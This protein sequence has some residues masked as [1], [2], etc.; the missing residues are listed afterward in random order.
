MVKPVVKE[1]RVQVPENVT[2]QVKSKTVSVE[3][4]RGSI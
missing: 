2:V 3:G 1:E 4:P